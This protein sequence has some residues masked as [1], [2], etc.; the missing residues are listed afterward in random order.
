M[1]VSI[2]PGSGVAHY[3]DLG[4]IECIY[5]DVWFALPR[6]L[7]VEFRNRPGIVLGKQVDAF[8]MR[9]WI[10]NWCGWTG[11]I[12]FHKYM[13]VSSILGMRNHNFLPELISTFKGGAESL[14]KFTTRFS[15]SYLGF[16][17]LWAGSIINCAILHH[18]VD[19]NYIWKWKI[20]SS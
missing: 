9:V 2:T 15:S 4:G 13:L 5:P 3:N 8:L 11:I 7:T 1:L 14:L 6:I 20:H 19:N 12:V 17:L 10:N 16:W 18:N